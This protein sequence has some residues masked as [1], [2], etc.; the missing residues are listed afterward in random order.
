MKPAAAA[1]EGLLTQHDKGPMGA[2][3]GM[4]MVAEIGDVY[5]GGGGGGRLTRSELAL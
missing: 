2:G 1:I 5:G 3:M 4:P